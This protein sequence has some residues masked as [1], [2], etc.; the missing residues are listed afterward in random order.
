MFL[1]WLSLINL[2]SKFF[3]FL[4]INFSVKIYIRSFQNRAVC[5]FP[6]L[7][8]TSQLFFQPVL[9]NTNEFI[10]YI[11]L[12]NFLWILFQAWWSPSSFNLILLI[13]WKTLMNLICYWVTKYMIQ[14]SFNNN[15]A[16]VLCVG[17]YLRFLIVSCLH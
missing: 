15:L 5:R 3:H 10:I 4:G 16:V 12:S 14:I 8:R 13:L 2:I 6:N 7:T 1:T 11:V 9:L 17:N